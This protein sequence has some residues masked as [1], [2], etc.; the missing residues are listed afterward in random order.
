MKPESTGS[1]A[2]HPVQRIHMLR[3]ILLVVGL[4]V[5]GLVTLNLHSSIGFS[6][7]M[8]HHG[9][10]KTTDSPVNTTVSTV[11]SL[12][13]AQSS[14]FDESEID[15]SLLDKL[16][17]YPLHKLTGYNVINQNT[18]TEIHKRADGDNSSVPGVNPFGGASSTTSSFEPPSDTTSSTFEQETSSTPQ[19]PFQDTTSSTPDFFPPTSE[20]TS[21]T[22]ETHSETT[23]ST[24]TST[25]EPEK[26]SETSKE[27]SSHGF[28]ED[29]GSETSET[30]ADD[31]NETSS[32]SPS[33]SETSNNSPSQTS[34]DTDSSTKTTNSPSET[35]SHVVTTFNSVDNGRTIVVTQTSVVTHDSQPSAADDKSSDNDN[36]G[37]SHTN[38]IVVGVVV[39]IGGSILVGLISVL[40][41]LKRRSNK[42]YGS[43]GWTF[44]R[45]NEKVGSED[46]FNGELGVRDRNINQGSNF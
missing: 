25:K 30:K 11:V 6:C 4:T 21:S 20:T 35:T 13:A 23:S 27:Q 28:T 1:Q 26:T 42:D 44:W 10:P 37:L 2:R 29:S 14:V 7:H 33:P 24:P 36:G 8:N 18:M 16:L 12:Q 41:Y 34:S 22:S 39:G 46:F 31:S 19:P 3:S 40:F 9:T 32:S 17:Q 43:G 15:E 45:K 38:R 5:I